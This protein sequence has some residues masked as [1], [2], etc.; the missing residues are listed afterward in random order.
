[1]DSH[2]IA[3]PGLELTLQTRLPSKFKLAEIC[4]STPPKC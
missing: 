2:F 4:L 3:P 1:M